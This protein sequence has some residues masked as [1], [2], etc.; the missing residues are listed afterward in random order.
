GF[1]Q[2][3]LWGDPP[4]FAMPDREG[5]I[6]MLSR[7]DEESKIIPKEN[8]WDMYFWVRNVKELYEEFSLRGAKFTQELTY[9]D[10]YGNNEFIVQAPEGY[11]LAFGQEV[12]DVPGDDGTFYGETEFRHM[13]PVFAS[14]DVRRDITWYEEK[15]GFKKVFDSGDEPLNYAGVT[16]Q[17]LF[18]HMQYQFPKDM[19]SSDLRIEVR[20]IQP[21]FQEYLNR[22]L[23]KEEAMKLNTAWGTNEFGL[24]D[25][26]G[27]RIHFY[28]D[29]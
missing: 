17:G 14:Q 22:G 2:P 20:N 3:R 1:R 26:S 28:E 25:P 19:W 9:K 4:G 8:I 6:V 29:I 12:E 15:L 18:L 27:N 21:L 10:Q 16:R 23:V 5:M 7:Q 24:F 13:N 11:T